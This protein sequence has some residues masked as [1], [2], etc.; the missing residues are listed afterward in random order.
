LDT[1]D[2]TDELAVAL[3]A[4]AAYFAPGEPIPRDLL[5]STVD[6]PD[7]EEPG[8]ALRIEE[9]L[10]RLGELGLLETEE[11]GAL[12]LHRLLAT[13]VRDMAVDMEAQEAVEAALLET[14]GSLIHEGYPTPLL[15]LQPHLR[16][17]TDAT[18][19][20]EDEQTALLCNQLGRYLQMIGEY[21]EAL[22]TW[23]ERWRSGRRCWGPSILAPSWCSK[24]W[25]ALKGMGDKTN[26]LSKALLISKAL[27]GR[28]GGVI[29][30]G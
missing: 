21:T 17:A 24:I 4:R 27:T 15:V 11:S 3:L 19:E 26:F 6:L 16:A 10:Q 14:A 18:K 12:R 28:P 25:Q 20:R 22:L 29:Q 8:A 9:A 2:P 1:V 23:S 30:C 5:V 7:E 13:F